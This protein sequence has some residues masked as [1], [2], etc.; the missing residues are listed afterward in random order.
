MQQ[1]VSEM[2]TPFDMAFDILSSYRHI[3]EKTLS[4][5]RMSEADVEYVLEHFSID[6]GLIFSIQRIYKKSDLSFSAFC[7]QMGYPDS[8]QRG[9]RRGHDLDFRLYKH[10]EEA[11]QAIEAGEPTVVATGTGSGKT[12]AFLIPILAHCLS[13]VSPGIKAI[14]LYPMNALANDQVIRLSAYMEETD[15]TFGI[16]TGETPQ[17]E[18]EN[19]PDGMPNRLWSR[20]RMCDS[21]PDILITN[22]VMLDRL[23]VD[24]RWRSIIKGCQGSLKY[25]VLD[26]IHSYRGTKA[27]HIRFLLTRLRNQT[28]VSIHPIG[29]SATISQ[30]GGYLSGTQFDQDSIDNFLQK[31]LGVDNCRLVTPTYDE[32]NC[33]VSPWPGEGVLID[34]NID[35]SS[36]PEERC[37]FLGDILGR[38]V[39]VSEY[40]KEKS[41]W[42]SELGTALQ[43]HPFFAEFIK[44]LGI[45]ALS[46]SEVVDL[47]QKTS[48]APCTHT[49]ASE[50]VRVWLNLLAVLAED[51]KGEKSAIDLRLH[52]FLLGLRGYLKRCLDCGNFHSG[53][54]EICPDCSQPLFLVDR[55]DISLC[56]AKINGSLISP[57]LDPE[58]NDNR[59]TF[60]VSIRGVTENET[61]ERGA[62]RV[63]KREEM[64]AGEF[65]IEGFVL[66]Y[67][68]DQQGEYI[69]FH[70]DDQRPKEIKKRLV[71]LADSIHPR[72]HMRRI[73][74]RMLQQLQLGKR[75]I[76]GFID[77]RERVSHDSLAITDEFISRFLKG[78]LNSIL[79]DGNRALNL[80]EALFQLQSFVKEQLETPGI[81]REE[82][83]ALGETESWFFRMIGEPGRYSQD[84]TNLLYI[85]VETECSELERNVL[86]VFI[87]ERALHFNQKPK[88]A[89]PEY[90][91]FQRHWADNE[92]QIYSDPKASPDT[93]EEASCISLSADAQEYK[94]FVAHVGETYGD[95]SNLAIENEGNVSAKIIGAELIHEALESLAD[96][97]ILVR[98]REEAPF[99]YALLSKHVSI[100]KSDKLDANGTKYISIRDK[101]FFLAANHSSELDQNDRLVVESK[102]R[103]G[104][105]NLLLSTPTLEMGIDIGDLQ[106]ILLIGIPPMP[107]NYAQRSGRAGR[108]RN[109]STVITYCSPDKDHD[110]YY[111]ERPK[112]MIDG[113]INAPT[114][115]D[116][117]LEVSKKH[118]RAL[119]LAELPALLNEAMEY[120]EPGSFDSKRFV[121]IFSSITGNQLKVELTDYMNGEFQ[122]ELE[123][124]VEGRNQ[125]NS[126]ALNKLYQS[127][128]LP[129]YGFNR[130]QVEVWDHEKYSNDGVGNMHSRKK[131]RDYL[132]VRELEYAYTKFT[133]GRTTFLASD[134]YHITAEGEWNEWQ[135]GGDEPDTMMDIPV[136]AYSKILA[137]RELENARMDS[138]MQLY[139][140]HISF[141]TDSVAHKIEGIIDL[142]YDP[143]CKI[144]FVNKG[145]QEYDI[146]EPFSDDV[147]NKFYLGYT[148]PR[149]ALIFGFDRRAFDNLSGPLS[150]MSSLD[151]TIKDVYGLD[152]SEL[153]MLPNIHEGS[154]AD[155]N[156]D[157]SVPY[158]FIIYDATGNGDLPFE[159]AV[160]NFN[161]LLEVASGRLQSCSHCQ[162]QG[163]DG[164][165]YCLK[166]HETQYIA[167]YAKKSEA[168]NV[169]DYLLGKSAFRP[170]VK[171]FQNSSR[172]EASKLILSQDGEGVIAREP[173]SGMHLRQSNSDAESVYKLLADAVRQF[174]PDGLKG[175]EI[176][177]NLEWLISN[178]NGTTKVGKGKYAFSE[179]QY[180][181]L[182]YNQV[183]VGRS[184]I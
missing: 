104:K 46:Y 49:Q 94:E 86:D 118:L 151:R 132:S 159:S 16:F 182:R 11:I 51:F 177:T 92:V 83:V 128:F 8:I 61:P 136:R 164:C 170:S 82:R 98:F 101:Y 55:N 58:E 97:N 105:I 142:K 32:S 70:L 39:R 108:S 79:P 156:A 36:L 167:P 95:T 43:S 5:G 140:R 44:Q 23:L 125:S 112:A 53:G 181:L 179:L 130:E 89:P 48:P 178:L 176:E 145:Y 17:E 100:R 93:R 20:S 2:S 77:D 64:M 129:D 14:L 30:L 73:V 47:F 155:S 91:R 42:Q 103:A 33:D 134:V 150:F 106:H 158:K 102:F 114:L 85:N 38:K 81:S 152:E 74:L 25:V 31:I 12:E 165:Y 126:S 148:L 54:Y 1:H 28:G 168:L 174:Y 65:P 76:L 75:K 99:R 180:E 29:A 80:D 63:G 138:G 90:I 84:R 154:A 96:K 6:R 9:L 111:Y 52:I 120:S 107:S 163:L 137:S 133:P 153:R 40:W 10:Q 131:N 26:E 121:S 18:P 147:G 88:F 56:V 157:Q 144:R 3:L 172:E 24:S 149:Q 7:A 183:W 62:I 161:H 162:K 141:D 19:V 166:S 67:R 27:T 71:K 59:K 123:S 109:F 184:Q 78:L 117:T 60:F 15:L 69:F 50:T 115:H 146:S 37:K 143:H 113:L 173:D 124:L 21:P 160:R 4:A 169:I 119:V 34:R 41:F 110:R 87:R 116:P 68:S 57:V 139:N 22:Y 45:G 13:S 122:N 35:L 72:I 171:P 127:G 135:L 66:P 175:L